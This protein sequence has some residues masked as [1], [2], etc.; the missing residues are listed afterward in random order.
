MGPVF[1]SARRCLW[2]KDELSGREDEHLDS[3]PS[4]HQ[5]EEMPWAFTSGRRCFGRKDEH[6]DPTYPPSCSRREE[7]PWEGG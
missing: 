5:W 1:T 3:R 7:I 4:I 6:S 2:R